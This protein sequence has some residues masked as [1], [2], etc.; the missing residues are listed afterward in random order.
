VSDHPEA[1]GTTVALIP[2][3]DWVNTTWPGELR[4]PLPL[5]SIGSPTGLE[6]LVELL[7]FKTEGTGSFEEPL[8]PRRNATAPITASALA[9]VTHDSGCLHFDQVIVNNLKQV[10][11]DQL[12]IDCFSLKCV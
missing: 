9:A 6:G 5:I 11:T 3:D 1:L 12:L 4:K 8:Q 10:V 2:V 7:T